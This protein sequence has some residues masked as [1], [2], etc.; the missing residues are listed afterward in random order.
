[1]YCYF[2]IM[3]KFTQKKGFTTLD[4][5]KILQAGFALWVLGLTLT[6][7]SAHNHIKLTAKNGQN[8]CSG[9]SIKTIHSSTEII[10]KNE[11]CW[12]SLLLNGCSTLLVQILIHS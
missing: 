4:F 2:K 12:N 5:C 10:Q 1:M 7:L 3:P 8:V 9:V 11:F 6:T